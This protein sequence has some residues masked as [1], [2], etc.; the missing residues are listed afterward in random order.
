MIL[1]LIISETQSEV[2]N[3]STI[4]CLSFLEAHTC[5]RPTCLSVGY[6]RQEEVYPWVFFFFNQYKT[7]L[8]L[9]P[10][11]SELEL[12]VKTETTAITTQGVVQRN[13]RPSVRCVGGSCGAVVRTSESGHQ[14]SGNQL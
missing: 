2:Y 6:H 3:T 13:G 11:K 4:L 9:N 12:S 5:L 1:L 14:V 7:T 8:R 10:Y